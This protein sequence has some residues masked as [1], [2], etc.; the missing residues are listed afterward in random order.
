MLKELV[1]M[2]LSVVAPT[3]Q[4]WGAVPPKPT[5]TAERLADNSIEL[6][7]E[8]YRHQFTWELTRFS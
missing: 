6:S 3:D 5:L 1:Y 2:V 8:R 4:T 7:W